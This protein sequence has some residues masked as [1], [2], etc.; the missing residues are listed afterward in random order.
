[1]S[2]APAAYGFLERPSWSRR[3]L[4]RLDRAW[5]ALDTGARALAERALTG[6]VFNPLRADL[7]SDPHPFYRELREADPFHRSIPAGGWV[8][9][10]YDDVQAALAE[11][12]FSADERNWRRWA[13]MRRRNRLAGLPDPY[14]EDLSSMLRLDAP[15]HTRLRHL[16]SKAFTARAVERMRDRVEQVIESLLEPMEGR[17]SM[18]LVA[19][20]AGPLPVIVI[21]EMLGVPGEDRDRFR[22]W[23][24]EVVRL[25]GEN[26]F[27]DARRGLR[28]RRELGAY[29]GEICERRRAEP[30]DD[31]ISALV[32]AEEEGDRLAPK[33]LLSTLVLLLV[34]GNETT[35]K[36][37]GNGL[38][39]LQGRREQWA[40]LCDEPQRVPHAVEELLRFDG[41]VQ[42]TSRMVLEDRTWRGQRLR[43]GEQLVLLLAGAN[44]DP[45]RFPDP[46]RL[47]VTRQDVRHL[48]FGHG[49]HFCI[50]AQL[51]RLEAALAF[52]ALVR[53]FP[54][55]SV[56]GDVAWG[57]NTVLRGP[58]R[59]PLSLG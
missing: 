4:H 26:D 37:I 31:L 46:D 52:R 56:S 48:S 49:A 36:L 5:F 42:L 47:D 15:D 35:T 28:A 40:L 57:D 12:G 9:S 39:A 27:D 16:V 54:D 23:S 14:D 53:R 58:I 19:D 29:L 2:E 59:V 41:S 17:R 51:A 13:R 45:D 7:R 43:R 33:E 30:R 38:L 50:G 20:F 1:M 3:T 22:F 55:L 21:A 25:L 6:I 10:R 34:A 8:L 44:R 24:D 18:E 32:A 11:R